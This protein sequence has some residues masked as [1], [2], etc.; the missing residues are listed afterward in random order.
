MVH[1]SPPLRDG[2]PLGIRDR[3]RASA[4]LDLRTTIGPYIGRQFFDTK[5]IDLTGEIGLV[6]VDERLDLS[7][8]QEL[9]G[10]ED[11][12]DYPG[13]NWAFHI[14]S[15]Y[16]G[17]SSNFYVDHDGILNFDDTE[18][19]LLNTTIGVKF[20]V[21]GGITAGVE[22]RFEYDGG[23]AEDRDEMDETYNF[24]VGYDW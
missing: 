3:D 9:A 17:G 20:N 1:G 7:E 23:V 21:Y 24:L 15:D 16:F 8:E 2:P 19:L 11:S 13:A 10:E 4:D 5:L 12:N 18:A 22:A 6:Y 14:T